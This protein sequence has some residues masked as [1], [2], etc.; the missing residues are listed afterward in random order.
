MKEKSEILLPSLFLLSAGHGWEKGWVFIVPSLVNSILAPSFTF[1]FFALFYII[2]TFWIII[3]PPS[4]YILFSGFTFSLCWR[5]RA[6]SSIS[7]FWQLCWFFLH[8][9]PFFSSLEATGST[10]FECFALL[11]LRGFVASRG[12]LFY[13]TLCLAHSW[14]SACLSV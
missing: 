5:F 9:Q 12:R 7:Y 8:H 10:Y 4:L 2:T 13:F 11:S 1:F 14:K 6:M 3:N